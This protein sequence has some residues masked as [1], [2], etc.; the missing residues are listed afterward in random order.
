MK[1]VLFVEG[2]APVG[3][4]DHCARLWNGTLLP[5]LD[6]T[7]VDVIVPI[8]KDAITNMLGLRGSSS[9]PGL[10]TRICETRRKH[11][12]DPDRDALIIAWDLEPIDEGKSRPAPSS[13]YA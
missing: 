4:R 13:V 8:G 2:S 12:L 9:A 7:P 11:H 10:D 1:I 6:R 3:S 5:A